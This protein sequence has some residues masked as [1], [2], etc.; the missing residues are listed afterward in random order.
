MIQM[1]KLIISLLLLCYALCPALPAAAQSL[2][3]PKRE[4]RGSWIQCVNGQFQGLSPEVMR[5]K[6]TQHLDA[7]QDIH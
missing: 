3:E 1:K 7:L 6:L 2:P 4:F 5:A